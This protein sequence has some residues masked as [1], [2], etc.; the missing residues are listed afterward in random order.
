MYM[1]IPISFII[2]IINILVI[3]IINILISISMTTN[4]INTTNHLLLLIQK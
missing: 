4:I 3:W 1:I 2:I